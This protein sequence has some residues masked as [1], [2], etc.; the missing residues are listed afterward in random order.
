MRSPGRCAIDII[1]WPEL[2]MKEVTHVQEVAALELR[3]TLGDGAGPVSCRPN[4]QA[5]ISKSKG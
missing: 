1:E 5:C 4:A 2:Q 3:P